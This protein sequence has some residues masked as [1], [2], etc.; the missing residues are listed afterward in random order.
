[1]SCPEQGPGLLPKG[2]GPPF[3]PNSLWFPF[4]P[5]LFQPLYFHLGC[6]LSPWH[7]FPRCFSDSRALRTNHTCCEQPLRCG[8]SLPH[9]SRG[10]EDSAVQPSMGLTT[11]APE[12][13]QNDQAS[14]LCLTPAVTSVSASIRASWSIVV[15]YTGVKV[16]LRPWMQ[17]KGPLKF[18]KFAFYYCLRNTFLSSVKDS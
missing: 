5:R 16:T 1:M 12:I 18:F 11:G 13:S 7:A 4:T 8:L 15:S 2:G 6:S 10:P 3:T 14:M 17:K 9:D